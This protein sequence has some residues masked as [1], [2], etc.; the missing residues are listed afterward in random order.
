MR[1]S[2]RLS[3]LW[4]YEILSIPSASDLFKF[5]CS[6][7]IHILFKF[8]SRKSKRFSCFQ[9]ESFLS[10]GIEVLLSI[11]SIARNAILVIGSRGGA[12]VNAHMHVWMHTPSV[13]HTLAW[14]I[15]GL[16][17]NWPP[18]YILATILELLNESICPTAQVTFASFFFLF[19]LFLVRPFFYRCE[20]FYEHC[21]GIG[22]LCKNIIF[23]LPTM[24]IILE[25]PLQC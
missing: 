11:E 24:V 1:R 16:N 8:I 4:V 12:C 23:R 22:A 6:V 2:V 17:F 25:K 13:H 14:E 9:E 7:L 21:H 5:K 10:L 19:E 3:I 18:L 15:A 20:C